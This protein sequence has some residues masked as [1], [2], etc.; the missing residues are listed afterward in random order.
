MHKGR[1]FEIRAAGLLKESRRPRA[2]GPGFV[3]KLRRHAG[4]HRHLLHKRSA[5][6]VAPSPAPGRTLSPCGVLV[7]QP[8][9]GVPASLPL[10]A[11]RGRGADDD[12]GD[13]EP[14]PSVPQRGHHQQRRRDRGHR[15]HRPARGDHAGD[16]AG[17][18]DRLRGR[19]LLQRPHRHGVRPGRARGAVPLGGALQPAGGQRVRGAVADH[20]H[21]QRRATGADARADGPDHDDRGPAHRGRRRG[22]GPAHRRATVRAAAGDHP[23]DGGGDRRADVAGG[24]AVP[25]HAGEDRQDQRGAAREPRRHPGDPRV[26]A[27]RP[28]AAPFRRRQRGPHRH[29]AAGDAAVR[30]DDAVADAD[31]QPVQ[32]GDHLVRRPVRRS[33]HHAD[34]R[35]HRVPGLHHADPVQRDDGRDDHGHGAAG[36]GVGRTHRRGPRH[37]PGGHRPGDGRRAGAA[38]R[39]RGVPRCR[40]PLPGRR[41]PGAVR[42]EPHDP[43]RPDHGGGRF[44]RLGQDHA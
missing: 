43:P 21:D 19:G 28:R 15:L 44:H 39:G 8:H 7:D 42:R 6:T 16:L 13:R 30:A 40:V 12:A 14:L 22:H 26:R 17:P 34:R 35:P 38:A 9:R 2:P 23:G 11:D 3:K 31:L 37:Q 1:G 33:G 36:G 10:G 4:V 20:A 41:G 29:R 24:A 32:R 5:A 25:V 18:R 27:H